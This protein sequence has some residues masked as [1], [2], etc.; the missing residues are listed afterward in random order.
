MGI[1]DGYSVEEVVS[2]AREVTGVD[3]PVKVTERRSGDQ[4]ILISGSDKAVSDLCWK[5]NFSDLEGIIETA[6]MWHQKHPRGY[7]T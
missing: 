1:G 2:V 5:P 3:I 7:G 6:W 4:A